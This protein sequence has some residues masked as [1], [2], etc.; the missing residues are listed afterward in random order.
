MVALFSKLRSYVQSRYQLHQFAM[1]DSISLSGSTIFAGALALLVISRVVVV[2]YRLYFHPLCSVPGPKLAA[3][4]S[5]YL[6]Y[7]E[8]A[9]GGGI[10]QS[11]PY[12]HK[13]Y[14]MLM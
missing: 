11:L 1:P 4:T 13:K 10:T 7:H 14:S 9:G 6:R 5:L 8:V 3:A 12:L 2:L